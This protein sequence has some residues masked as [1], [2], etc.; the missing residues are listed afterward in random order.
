MAANNTLK[1]LQAPEKRLYE[2]LTDEVDIGDA[3]GRKILLTALEAHQRMR[4]AR[5]KI[6]ADGMMIVD[7]FGQ[8]KPHPLLTVERD[9]RAQFMAALKMLN[10][11]LLP[12]H[13]SVGRPPGT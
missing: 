8:Q 9:Q 4:K 1:H 10:I 12:N 13:P 7:R 3:Y 5:E 11:D 2:D 6:D